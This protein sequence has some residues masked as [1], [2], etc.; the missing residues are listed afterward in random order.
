MTSEPPQGHAT[1]VID[2]GIGSWKLQARLPVP[3]DPVPLQN[4]LPIIRTLADG[5]VDLVVKAVEEQGKTIS[6]TKGCGACCR[7]LVPISQVEARAIADLVAN[8]PEP[9]RAEILGRFSV[10]RERLE[11]SGML[12]RLE[13]RQHWS[14]EEFRRIGTEY[15]ELGIPCPF[16]EEESCS[17]HADRPITCREYLVM[18][19]ATNCQ[20]PTE[21][22]IEMVPLPVKLWREL[23]RFDDDGLAATFLRW[24]PLVLAPEWAERHPDTAARRPG[25]EWLEPVLES[26]AAK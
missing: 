22:T 18:S 19:P 15:F 8:L 9:R 24:V 14:E 16:L 4:L 1:A 7:Q 12:D 3:E 10:I 23:A 20:R 5:M 17:I 26:L 2:L 11:A 21:E 25:P 6:C 13:N